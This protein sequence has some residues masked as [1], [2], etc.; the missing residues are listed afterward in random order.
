MDAD[1]LDLD[2]NLDPVQVEENEILHPH[3]LHITDLNGGD[4]NGNDGLKGLQR[5]CF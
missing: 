4:W 2:E 1:N 3:D 5:L